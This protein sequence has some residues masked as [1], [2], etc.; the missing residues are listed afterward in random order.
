MSEKMSTS[1]TIEHV[2]LLL[3]DQWRGDALGHLG[4][5]G[6]S[7]PHLDALAA[8]GVSFTNHWCQ[9]SPCGPSRGSL[10][11]SRQ[12]SGHGLWTHD[13]VAD[14][15]MPSL[16]QCLKSHNVRPMLVGYTDTP[17]KDPKTR[18]GQNLFDPSF[19]LVRPFFWQIA[20]PEYREWLKE[21]GYELDDNMFSIYT[22]SGEPTADYL[23][24]SIVPNIH[25]D[26]TWL[27]DAS[28][29]ALRTTQDR[30]LLHVNWL[31][32]HPPFAP[33]AP[34]HT[35][36]SPDEVVVPKKGLDLEAQA[37]L[38]PFF[39]GTVKGG[40][41]WEYLQ[42]S[43]RIEDMT[44]R[45]EHIARASYYGHCAQVDHDVG[46]IVEELKQLG[47]WNNT[48]VIFLSDHGDSFGE[49]WLFGRQGVGDGHFRVPCIIRDP[50]SYA[51]SSRGHEVHDF[52]TNMDI[53]PTILKA[54]D[55]PVPESIE[56]HSLHPFLFGN[57]VEQWRQHV[58]YDMDWSELARDAGVQRFSAIRTASHRFV[59]FTNFEPLLFDLRNDPLETVNL[60]NDPAQ[61]NVVREFHDL[62][63]VSE[64][65]AASG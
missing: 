18:T 39:E 43:V 35:L 62:L 32:P 13:D 11:F 65:V 55:I 17:T 34:Y 12:V 2:L 40:N 9:A 64:Q 54:F 48:L 7:T 28:L 10:H 23:A 46:R 63:S 3:P 57:T 41:L 5:A 59:S 56:G 6:V 24:P 14:F 20:F 15:T 31:R 25:S 37:D 44:E 22:P 4:T 52:T 26:V 38:H 8:E 49:H 19:D 53:M 27:T 36:V 51:D 47:R 29:E 42:R 61:R 58:R 50:R 1:N 21:L 16:A 30:S 60:A 33:P 45:D